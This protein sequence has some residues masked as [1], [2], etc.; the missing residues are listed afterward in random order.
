MGRPEADGPLPDAGVVEVTA[1]QHD[2]LPAGRWAPGKVGR[3]VGSDEDQRRAGPGATRRRDVRSDLQ[4]DV[5]GRRE[6][7][8]VVQAPGRRR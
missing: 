5:G 3:E 4:L 1:D 6:P 7:Q 8:Q 2:V